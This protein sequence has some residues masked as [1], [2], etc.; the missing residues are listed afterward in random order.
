MKLTFN[1]VCTSTMANVQRVRDK[2]GNLRRFAVNDTSVRFQG[3]IADLEDDTA[4]PMDFSFTLDG[5]PDIQT[6]TNYRLDV[7]LTPIED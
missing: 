2:D 1:T 7:T 4:Y 6:G 5:V 3:A